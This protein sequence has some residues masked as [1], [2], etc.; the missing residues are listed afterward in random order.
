MGGIA[1]D[2]IW[3]SLRLVTLAVIEIG[4]ALKVNRITNAMMTKSTPQEGKSTAGVTKKGTTV[5]ATSPLHKPSSSAKVGP[6]EVVGGG[7]VSKA[8]GEKTAELVS[9]SPPESSS[10][11]AS[12]NPSAVDQFKLKISKKLY[13][14]GCLMIVSATCMLVASIFILVSGYSPVYSYIQPQP[15]LWSF[16]F[17]FPWWLLQVS[18]VMEVRAVEEVMRKV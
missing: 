7:V 5:A 3:K 9:P 17:M 2:T 11:P 13:V 10:H 4:V 6:S 16:I 8:L 12:A 14:L 1:G 15:Y 18:S